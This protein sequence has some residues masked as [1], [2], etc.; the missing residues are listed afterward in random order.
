MNQPLPRA[1]EIIVK[2]VVTHTVTYFAAGIAAFSLFDYPALF[3]S[4]ELGLFMRPFTDPMIA[5]GP[6][7]QPVRG[8]LFGC[9]FY[10]LREPFFGRKNGWL[11]MWVVL[12]SLGIVGT[13]AAPPGS[14]E[15]AIYTMLPLSLHLKLLPELLIQS[16][17]LSWV[18]FNWV[19][20]PQPWVAWVMAAAFFL[21]LLV[22]L[23]ALIA[24]ANNPSVS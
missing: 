19:T 14:I 18:L 16:L 1:R 13:F 21:V 12:A 4:T 6:A 3:A 10:L 9:V 20:R 2:T 5:A 17:L 8:L 15:G 11:V 24:N 22:P 7:L 23:L